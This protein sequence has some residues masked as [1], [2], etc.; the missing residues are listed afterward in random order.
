VPAGELSGIPAFVVLCPWAQALQ[1]PP[2]ANVSVVG[3]DQPKDRPV[4]SRGSGQDRLKTLKMRPSSP[5]TRLPFPA[6][7]P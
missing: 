3:I 5:L 6:M 7:T 1:R 2:G 4:A